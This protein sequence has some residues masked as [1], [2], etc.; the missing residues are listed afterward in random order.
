WVRRNSIPHPDKML[1][2]ATV[3]VRSVS[4]DMLRKRKRTFSLDEVT[5]EPR[6]SV[7][8]QR[9]MEEQEQR[10][11]LKQAVSSLPNKQQAIVRMRNVENLSY[12]EIASILGTTESSVRG[13][14]CRVRATLINKLN[15]LS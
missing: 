15:K 2:F 3:V 13:T 9:M 4:I 7:D 1:H 10:L 6:N 14:L 11:L 5:S 12:A 8:A